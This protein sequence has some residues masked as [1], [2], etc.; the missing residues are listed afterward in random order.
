MNKRP[1]LGSRFCGLNDRTWVVAP[2]EVV[3]LM[4]VRGSCLAEVVGE[5]PDRGLRLFVG[6]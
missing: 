3:P 4:E 1:K 5:E 2:V 6:G